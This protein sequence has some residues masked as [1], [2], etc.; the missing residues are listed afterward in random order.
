MTTEQQFDEWFE[1]FADGQGDRDFGYPD[2]KEAFIAGIESTKPKPKPA[3]DGSIKPPTMEEW[4]DE[5]RSIGF[6]EQEAK[7]SYF[8]FDSNG[9]MAGKSKIK[10]WKSSL[11]YCKQRHELGKQFRR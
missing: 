4:L 2:L 11:Q 8:H 10:N 9:W 1:G 5:A 7:L 6:P 3:A